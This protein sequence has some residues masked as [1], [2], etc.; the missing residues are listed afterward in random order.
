M[1]YKCRNALLYR[2]ISY[3]CITSVEVHCCTGIYPTYVLHVLKYIVVQEYILHMYYKFRNALLY[4]NISFTCITCVEVHCCTGIYPLHVLHV[5]KYR[6]NT[7]VA[8][9]PVLHMYYT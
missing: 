9:A 5:L 8:D 2:N 1:Y 7:C 4:R 6:Y 3:T